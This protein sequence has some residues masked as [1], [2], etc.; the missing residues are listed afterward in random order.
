MS[1]GTCHREIADIVLLLSQQ[2]RWK[3]KGGRQMNNRELTH[4]SAA[5]TASSLP[6]PQDVLRRSLPNGIIVLAR[7]NWSAPSVVMEGYVQVGNLDEPEQ[8]TGLASFTSA[9]LGR[10]TRKRSFT[11]INEL[12][13]SVG[14]SLGFSVDRRLTSFSAKA[15]AE[16]LDLIL[17]VMA[18]E[19][20]GPIFPAE[21]VERLRGLRMTAIAEREND[22]RRMVGLAFRELMYG[23]HPLGRDLLGSRS[24]NMAIRRDDLVSFYESYYRP[25]GM[26]IAIV[27]AVPAEIAF[28][29][30]AETFGDWSGD[31]IAR[32]DLPPVPRPKERRERRVSMPGKSQSDIILGWPAMRRL[33]PDFDGA[34]MAN[35]VLGV[36]GMMG[37]LGDKVREEQGMAYY[38]YSRLS[39]NR[40]PGTWVAIAG[41]A[42]ENMDRALQAMLAEVGRLREEPV[43]GEELQDCKRYLTG[44]LPIQLETND[45]VA[46]VLADIEWH[47]LGLDYIQ[48]YKGIIDGTTPE[49][50]QNAA[51]KYL[52][53]AT[54]TLAIAGP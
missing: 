53:L 21:Y 32:S 12:V 28:Q 19:L 26:L 22:T 25:E 9:M 20:R 17:D 36:F 35:T 47:G 41:V 15:L 48:R 34:R 33:D 29:K 38:A 7:E 40:D 49:D 27:G 39:A 51:R 14:A 11:E 37:R 30:V 46:G 4:R 13:E 16:D 54:Y 50:V 45:G 5:T 23:D 52:D 24:S 10:G 6:G 42:P 31:R 18:D 3:A 8:L 2:D 1:A 43:P 44:S